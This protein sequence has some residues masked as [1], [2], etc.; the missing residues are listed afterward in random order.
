MRRQRRSN[1]ALLSKSQS[2]FVACFAQKLLAI[3]KALNSCLWQAAENLYWAR[4]GQLKALKG[5]EI[6]AA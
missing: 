5:N 4:N 3:H 1:E 6:S 2:N